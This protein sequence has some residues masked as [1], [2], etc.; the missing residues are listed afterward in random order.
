MAQI[1]ALVLH[2]TIFGEPEAFG[3][4]ARCFNLRHALVTHAS[5]VRSPPSLGSAGWPFFQALQLRS[6]SRT[7]PE[8]LVSAALATRTC[9]VLPCARCLPA[10]R[11]PGPAR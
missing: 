1:G 7:E 4:A 11:H 2:S 9:C 10:G 6:A 8:L 5:R 3:G